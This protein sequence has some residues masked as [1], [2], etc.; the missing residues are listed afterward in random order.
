MKQIVAWVSN[1][2]EKLIT[3][4]FSDTHQLNFVKSLDELFF[5]E[6]S[7]F[8]ISL[9]KITNKNIVDKIKKIENQ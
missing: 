4:N 8:V 3:N 9:S 6:N 7:V 1:N 2:H 5:Y